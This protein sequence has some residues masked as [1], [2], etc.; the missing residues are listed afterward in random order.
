M[1]LRL[2]WHLT[3]V[4]RSRLVCEVPLWYVA[5]LIDDEW[6]PLDCDFHTSTVFVVFSVPPTLVPQT[7]LYMFLA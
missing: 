2:P 3:S 6:Q 5:I 4:D 7:I 1:V